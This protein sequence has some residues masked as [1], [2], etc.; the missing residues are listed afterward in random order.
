[1]CTWVILIGAV[2][3]FGDNQLIER[4]DLFMYKDVIGQVLSLRNLIIPNKS[5]SFFPHHLLVYY[6]NQN[7]NQKNTR[8]KVLCKKSS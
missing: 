8:E 6:F 4:V 3:Y 1:M 2:K 5:S 7:P